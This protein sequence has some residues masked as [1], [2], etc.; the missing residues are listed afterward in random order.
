MLFSRHVYS[1]WYRRQSVEMDCAL[2]GSKCFCS[3]LTMDSVDSTVPYTSKATTILSA[4][5]IRQ[6]RG[7]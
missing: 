5:V 1:N 2:A 4:M 3:E 6:L 7:T